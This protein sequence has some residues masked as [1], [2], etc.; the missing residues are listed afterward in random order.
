[1]SRSAIKNWFIV[2]QWSSIICTLF[3]LMLCVTG[4]PLIFHDEIDQAIGGGATRTN[5]A[6]SASHGLPLDTLVAKAVAQSGGVPLFIGFSQD[7][8][9]LTVTTGPHPGAA[10]HQM[11]LFSFDR[12]TG[13]A[14]GELRDEGVMHFILE[15]HTDMFL[16]LPG[17]FMLGAM[18]VL[19]VVALVSGMALYLPFMRRLRFGALRVDRGARVGHLDYHNLL[20]VV[21]LGWALVVGVTGVIN[22]FGDPL[23]DQWR[24]GELARMVGTDAN[25][26][27]VSPANY[28]SIDKALG[29]A[30]R[31]QPGLSPQFIAFPGGRWSSGHHFAIFF[32]GNTPLTRH[33]LTPALVDAETAQLTDMRAMP[34]LNQALMLSKP[35]H[36]GDYGGLPLKLLWAGFDLALI[37][38]LVTGVRLWL[39]RS[40]KSIAARVEEIATGAHMRA[41]A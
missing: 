38:V 30:Q 21:T 6:A 29:A 14:I 15:L 28:A 10:E 36:F 4:L 32:Q 35:L 33:V 9:I 37:W 31:H 16:G 2:H 39:G 19:F 41:A 1:L 22:A 3:L 17:M 26:A 5:G 18:G 27:P 11:R 40:A 7:S 25:R 20:G 8:P 24:E 23:T 12:S 13:A 34:A